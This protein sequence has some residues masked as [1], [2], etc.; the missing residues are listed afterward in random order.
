M[1][2]AKIMNFR[3][4]EGKTPAGGGGTWYRLIES[5]DTEAGLI[6]GFGRIKPDDGRGWHSHPEGEDEIFYVIEGKGLGEWKFEGK[7][8]K[9][10]IPSGTA[11]Y[12]PGIMENNITNVGD[13][14]LLCVYCIYKP[15]K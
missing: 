9:Q 1:K 7:S 3:E 4:V 6:F 5:A 10:E 11:F 15:I 12:T 14:D 2:N 8:Y 13:K